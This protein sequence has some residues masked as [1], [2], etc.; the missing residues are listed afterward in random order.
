LKKLWAAIL[1]VFF[2]LGV[3]GFIGADMVSTRIDQLIRDDITG[4]VWYK[5][6]A[7]FSD[8]TYR[9]QLDCIS[10]LESSYD[11][12]GDGYLDKL[13]WRIATYSDVNDLVSNYQ[14]NSEVGRE[15]FMDNFHLTR[16]EGHGNISWDEEIWGRIGTDTTYGYFK[17]FQNYLYSPTVTS[18]DYVHDPYGNGEV[19]V[20]GPFDAPAPGQI[21]LALENIG[22]W[23]VA[24]VEYGPI[25]NQTEQN[26]TDS[27]AAGG[28]GGGGCFINSIKRT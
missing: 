3:T 16:L 17:I 20:D 27:G 14:L 8:R 12:N 2:V 28:N 24:N 21:D 6:V 1:I 5:D 19:A 15:E 23:A 11:I 10:L 22:A 13:T 26:T 9:Q 7:S 4:L 25:E 18:P